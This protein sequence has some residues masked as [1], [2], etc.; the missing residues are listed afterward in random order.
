MGDTKLCLLLLLCT[1]AFALATRFKSFKKYVY[2]YE[3]ETLN[4]VSGTSDFKNGPRVT[5]KVE[6]DVPQ[7]CSYIVRTHECTLSEVSDIDAEGLPVYEPAAGAD[8]FQAAME[9]NPLKLTVE[10]ESKVSLFPEEDE[11]VNI[12]NIKRGIISALLVPVL[13]EESNMKMATLHGLCKTDFAVNARED[14]ATDVTV[15]RDLSHCDGFS[16]MKDFTSPLALISGLH[17]DLQLQIDNEK[18]HMTEGTCTEKHILLPFSHQEEYGVLTL[19]KQTLTLQ[20]T[21]KINDRVFEHNEANLKALHTEAVEDKAPA[22]TKDA[23]LATL[24]ELSTLSQTELGKR[25]AH[26]FQKLVTEIRGLKIEALSAAVPEMILRTKDKSAL[27]VDAAVYV[28]GLMPN[29]NNHLVQDM[30]SMAQHKPSKAILYGL[31]NVVRRFYQAEGVT[32]EII[33]VSEYMASLV[34]DC[35]GDKDQ[36]FL[37]LRVIGNM[38]QAMEAANPALKLRSRI[39]E[40]MEDQDIYTHSEYNKFSRNY[41]MDTS[42]AVEGNMIFDLNSYMPKEVMLETTLKAFGYN[43]DMLEVGMEGKGFEPTIEALFGENGFFP[44]TVSKAMYWVEDKIPD[45]I[46]QVLKNWITPQRNGRMKRQVP[47]NLMREIARNA[48]KLV[49]ELQ[50]Q[51]SPEATAYLRIMGAELGYLK[52]SDLKS[53][54]QSGALYAEMFSRM[55][56]SKQELSFMPSIGAE[57]VTKM[58]VN[59]P[60]FVVSGI[61]MHTNIYHESALR[62]KVTMGEGQI[63]LAIPAPQHTTRLFEIS[64]NLYFVSSGQTMMVPSIAE[65]RTDTVECSPLFYGLQYCSTLRYSASSTEDAP[66]FPLTGQTEF[67]LDVQATGHVAEYTA[68]IAY[69]L[70]REGK[71]GRQKVDALRLI[72]KA[73]GAVPSEATGTMKYNRNRNVLTTDF[74]IPDYDVETGI[75]I[76]V[77]DSSSK[78]KKITLDIINK[79][80]PQLSLVGRAKF[81]GA[82]DGMLQVQLTIPSFKTDATITAN[83]KSA[84]GLTLGLESVINVPET[85]IQEEIIFRYD[86][87]RVEVEFKSDMSSE[88]QK[89]IPTAE[90]YQR[91]LQQFIDDILDQK[92]AK[93]D[94]NMRHI[95]SKSLEASSIWL[96]K[97][98]YFENLRN[99][100]DFTLPALPE[101]LFLKSETIFRYQF[102]NGRFTIVLP[103]PLAGY[104]SQDL[105]IPPT[106]AIPQL[107]V[108]KTGLEIPYTVVS[109]PTFIIPP[110]YEISVPLIGMAEVSAKVNSN[111]YN[112]EGLVSAGNNTV[113]TPSYIAK[114]QVMA[115]SPMKLFSYKMEGNALISGTDESMKAIINGSLIHKFIDASFSFIETVTE[116]DSINGY[117][118]G[119]GN[120][121][122]KASSP[123]G[124]TSSMYLTSQSTFTAPD[125]LAGDAKLDGSIKLGSMSATTSYTQSYIIHPIQREAKGESTLRVDTPLLHVHHNIKGIYDYSQLSLESTIDMNN[126]HLK[127]VTKV[128]ISYNA[129]S[130]VSLKSDSVSTAIGTTL[131]NQVDLFASSD[132]ASFRVETQAD[133]SPNRAYSLLSGSLNSRSL[134]I[135]TDASINFNS[136]QGSH[137]AT[138]MINS[139]GLSTSGTTTLQYSPLT[140]ENA[141]NGGL[142]GSGATMSIISKGSSL[143]NSVDLSVEG[144]IGGSE[145]YLNS[146]FKGILFEADSRNTMRLKLDQEGLTF[147]NNLI[148]SLR[149]MKT[150][151][152]QSL[153]LTFFTLA[154]QSTSD[155][156]ISDTTSYKHDIVVDMKNFITSVHVINELKIFDA[157]FKNEGQLKLEPYKMELTGSQRGAFREE[158]IRHTY[159]MGYA[160]WAGKM[161]C[162]TTGRILGAQMSLN[163][164]LEVS[165]LSSSKLKIGANINSQSVR[166]DSSVEMLATPYDLSIDAILN[167]DGDLV[168][169]GTHTG[170]LYSKLV[171]KAEPMTITYSYDCRASTAHKLDS[172]AS[173]ETSIDNQFEGAMD[174]LEQHASWRVKST[175]NKHEYKQEISTYN[176]AERIGLELSGTILTDLLNRPARE[177]QEFSISGFLK[178]DKSGDRHIISLPFIDSLPVIFEQLKTII[179]NLKDSIDKYEISAKIQQK[180]SELKAAINSFDTRLFTDDLRIFVSSINIE[181]YFEML[182]AQIP[183][184]KITRFIDAIRLGIIKGIKKLEIAGKLNAVHIKVKEL[185]EKYEIEKIVEAIVEQVSR[186]MKQY[187]IRERMQAVVDAV[188][189]IDFERGIEKVRKELNELVN[190][191]KAIDFGKMINDFNEFIDRIVKRIESVDYKSIVEEV[192]QKIKIPAFGKIY[193]EF[194]LTS[195]EYKLS[196]TAVLQ[197]TTAKPTT[198]Q[199]TATLNSEAITD[200][201]FLAY[202]L[203]A[204]AHIA[205]PKMNRLLISESMKVTHSAFSVDHQSSATLYSSS[206]VASAKTTVKATTEPYTADFTNSASLSLNG[207]ISGSLETTYN[208]NLNMPLAD[209]S[210]QATITQTSTVKIEPG[211]ISVTLGNAGNGKWSVQHHSDEGTHKSDLEVTIDVNTAKLSFTSNTDSK[212][213]KLK[214]TV[215]AESAP[216]NYITIN[217]R[218]ETEMPFIKSSVMVLNGK[219]QIP[220][221]KIELI[222][223]HDTELVGRVGAT[224]SNSVNFLAQPFEFALDC[225]NKGNG[226]IILPFRL[227][228]KINLQNDYI[229]I[230]NSEVQQTSW[231]G[232]ARFNQYKY[233]HH[234]TMD[235]NK[236]DIALYTAMS[237]EANLDL[238]NVPISIPEMTVPLIDMKTPSVEE[239]SLW[240][241]TGL[242]SLLTTTQQSFDLNFKLQYQKNPEMYAIPI[243][244]E[245]VYKAIGISARILNQNFVIGRDIAVALVTSSYNQAKGQY[246]KFKIDTSNYLPRTFEFPGYTVPIL[247]IEV[248]PFM[249][250][251]PAMSFVIPKEISTPSFTMPMVGFSVPS[252]II[253]L[254]VMEMPVIHVPETLKQLTLPSITLPAMQKEIIIPAMG[255]MTYDFSFKSAVITLTSSAGLYNQE[256][257]VAKFGV[258]STSVFEILKSKLEGSSTLTRKRGLKLVTAMSLEHTNVESTHESIASLSKKGMETSM[259]TTGKIKLPTETLEFNQEFIGNAKDGISASVFSPSTGFIGFQL[260]KKPQSQVSGR[261][262]GRYSTAPENDVE[263]LTVKASL[264][265]PEKLSFQTSWNTEIPYQMILG[266]KERVPDITS[267]LTLKD[268][269]YNT[270]ETV[271]NEIPRT[272]RNL[273]SGMEHMKVQGKVLYKRAAENF[274]ELNLQEA[275]RKISDYVKY[276]FD[277]YQDNVKALLDAVIKFL[278]ETHFQL[279]GFEEKLTGLEIYEKASDFVAMVIKDAIVKVPEFVASYAKAFLDLIKDIEFT[280]PG[281]NHIISGSA[282]IEDLASNLENVQI[283]AISI[284]RSFQ[285]ISLEDILERLRDCLLFAVKLADDFV[286]SL[287]SQ[288]MEKIL[289][290]VN[291]LYSDA[292]NSELLS[293]LSVQ[294]K[295]AGEAAAENLD[296]A[297]TKLQ[298]AYSQMTLENLNTILQSLIDRIVKGLNSFNNNVIEFLKKISENVQPYLRVSDKKIDI[299]I[300]LPFAWKSANAVPPQNEQ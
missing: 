68:T 298:E 180:A 54:V 77:S 214:Q 203:E 223:S 230:L 220:N 146:V 231:V 58:G 197:N 295:E 155:N 41:K 135:N 257:I 122:I 277:Q 14:I 260:Q 213:L 239:V 37:T 32:P 204:T 236:N 2:R 198:P 91:Q 161:K 30:L 192:R 97:L 125:E 219:V 137:K 33:A 127:H 113:D 194:T 248:A 78:G 100:P 114:Y 249:A 62:A 266:L 61:E 57:F 297:K 240:E 39:M 19:V 267:A 111:F 120:Y 94:M 138:L 217:A 209:I 270:I 208:H 150:D 227:T 199:F 168:L 92:V 79:N 6:I 278:K 43:L 247:N 279:P 128:H 105:N 152:T 126:D 16:P 148:G 254:P 59:I 142:D 81:E 10:G 8:A 289:A 29:P 4:G 95:Y 25:R 294:L 3:T 38:G 11:P 288:N 66:Y 262:F 264:K 158:E 292:V 206:A 80:V 167:S 44:D 23:V 86:E 184:E 108:P 93:T 212:T 241:D 178:Y 234:F 70:L 189:S 296:L 107:V 244:T 162:S 151:S 9:K 216:L 34:G 73:E 84:D 156:S 229:M 226:K 69:E 207:G 284:V 268:A 172:G 255:N 116:T 242:K 211:T 48:N 103:L 55:M 177:N 17:P 272:A 99:I 12:L 176:N 35:S 65:G 221:L 224:L 117:V 183:T 195:P 119:T 75:K 251:F 265:D 218:S 109:I 169:Y 286:D 123:L 163:T 287:T 225:K 293:N 87:N 115:D 243:N 215:T 261:L 281:S 98:P 5:C 134:E 141:F 90:D 104:S 60:E 171:L 40:V 258:S 124:L 185:L 187:K 276:L 50:S 21:S 121:I 273:Q 15:T 143:Q 131:R 232:L 186:L 280:L 24:T 71:D 269:V 300:P 112:W 20:E 118:N 275:T 196:T 174:P 82:T 182:V 47:D 42:L 67:A 133:N 72:L 228:G 13:E 153:T 149:D 102:K 245:P 175:L 271:Y 246:E 1:Y 154:F 63:K 26:L 46:N 132:I 139:D 85:S 147:F 144:K 256:D 129:D 290:W 45:K 83:L 160:E 101:K 282:V 233:S 165:G 22:Q 130:T 259:K 250:E 200:N 222:A 191:L 159:E 299:D 7:T 52:T 210:S 164:D 237:G 253:V 76:G 238:L 96:D 291:G 157:D 188:K 36:T 89:L 202:T 179:A 51:E 106:V 205:A 181:E 170:Q 235:N 145:A 74:Q 166:L 56:P 193:G 140:F 28:M 274:A 173:S 88:V 18:K 49:K 283:N 27:E 64:N 285:T 53:L 110:S 201:D 31:S 252:Y 263:I 136:N 190:Q